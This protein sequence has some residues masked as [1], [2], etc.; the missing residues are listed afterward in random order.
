MRAAIFIVSCIVAIALCIDAYF[1]YLHF[2]DD[3]R[4]KQIV[5]LVNKKLTPN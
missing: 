2:F 4:A 1:I 3:N 5:S